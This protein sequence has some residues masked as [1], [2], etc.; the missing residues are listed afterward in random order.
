[1]PASRHSRWNNVSLRRK[2][3]AIM[4]VPL[5]ALVAAATAFLLVGRAANTA[6]DSVVDALRVRQSVQD[7]DSAMQNLDTQLWSGILLGRPAAN[8]VDAAQ[9][10]INDAVAR[11]RRAVAQ[12]PDQL[13]ELEGF[14]DKVARNN[15]AMTSMVDTILDTIKETGQLPDLTQIFASAGDTLAP[16]V[17]LARVQQAADAMVEERTLE[18]RRARDQV[19]TT[20]LAGAGLGAIGGIALVFFAVGGLVRR[21]RVVERNARRLAEGDDLEP[22]DSARDEIGELAHELQEAAS[23]LARRE[24]EMV[25]A[26]DDAERSNQAKTE[27]L[28][29]MSHELRTPLNSVIG[30]GQLITMGDARREDCDSAE[31]IVRAGRHLLG[32]IDE[33]L[34]I[35]RIEGGRFRMS[36]ESV[37]IA[38]VIGESIDLIRP[39]A[40]RTNVAIETDQTDLWVTADRQRLNQVLLNLLSNAIK[41][42]RT[43]GRVNV[44]V[45][46]EGSTV[47]IDVSDTGHGIDAADIERL[48]VPFERLDA[49]ALGVEGTGLGLALS[50]RLVE[51]MG[52]AIE[53]TSEL[54]AGTTFAVTL[55]RAEPAEADLDRRDVA[56]APRAPRSNT[57]PVV[58]YI[59]DNLANLRLVERIL[60]HLGRSRLL[61]AMQGG[62]G[63][64]LARQQRPDLILLDLHLP[65]IHG[66]EVLRTLKGDPATRDIPVVVITADATREARDGVM[67]DGAHACMTKPLDLMP[68]VEV[69]ESILSGV[70][71]VA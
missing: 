2:I 1:M 43:G 44:S 28:S 29:R 67:T 68:F 23:L 30:F 57:E 7:V 71:A 52:G 53:V 18:A 19:Q 56:P 58:L 35:S 6:Q 42:N 50:R 49:D 27:F 46:S 32:L 17:A 37:C 34:D 31:Q 11:L 59:E 48:F 15:A 65:D 22:I 8:K 24:S 47:R 33:V 36:L 38:D 64:E 45:V 14:E 10:G 41:F 12:E 60:A 39:L 4:S 55:S 25:A 61:T 21:I 66:R 13:A 69:V 16:R 63:I 70:R 3:L 40:E 5:I 20:V 51:A 9:K 62:L 54:G 26:K